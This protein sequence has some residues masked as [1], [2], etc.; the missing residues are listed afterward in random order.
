MNAAIQ[1]RSGQASSA[2]R[3]RLRE[4]DEGDAAFAR[5]ENRVIATA[6]ASLAAAGATCQAGGVAQGREKKPRSDNLWCH[7]RNRLNG[8]RWSRNLLKNAHQHSLIRFDDP[9]AGSSISSSSFT[10]YKCAAIFTPVLDP[11]FV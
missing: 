6:Q 7:R 5:V 11:S 3:L 8:Q 9:R 2:E 1:A 10:L 4:F